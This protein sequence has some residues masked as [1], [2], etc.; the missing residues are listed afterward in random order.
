VRRTPSSAS[1]PWSGQLRDRPTGASAAGQGTRPTV[2]AYVLS[3]D[4]KKQYPLGG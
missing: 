1:D 4:L 2:H 3:P